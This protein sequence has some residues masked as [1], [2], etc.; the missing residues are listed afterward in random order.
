MVDSQ[1]FVNIS[2]VNKIPYFM[3][4]VMYEVCLYLHV[5]DELTYHDLY[6]DF[7]IDLDPDFILKLIY[8]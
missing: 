1:L 6:I 5:L 8:V 3:R 2:K 7:D 4:V